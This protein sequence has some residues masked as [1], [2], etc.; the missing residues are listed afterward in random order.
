M[1]RVVLALVLWC[2]CGR[3][4][5]ADGREVGDGGLT[6]SHDGATGD[7]AVDAS[8][9]MSAAAYVAPFAGTSGMTSPA[10]FEATAAHVGDLVVFQVSCDGATSP[11]MLSAPGWTITEVGTRTASAVKEVAADTFAAI[12][13]TTSSTT[14]TVTFNSSC[15]MVVLADELSAGSTIDVVANSFNQGVCDAGGAVTTHA[16]DTIWAACVGASTLGPLSAGYTQGDAPAINAFT[17][18]RVTT[19]PAGTTEQPKLVTSSV[20]VMSVIAIAPG[21]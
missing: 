3:L 6:F 18:Y 2:G 12:A 13:P 1:G 11:S 5:F 8:G 7:V 4:D 20:S 16:N 17:E 21:S 10:T 15:F 19:D 14:F 9:E